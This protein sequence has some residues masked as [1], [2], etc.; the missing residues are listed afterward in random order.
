MNTDKDSLLNSLFDGKSDDEHYELN[1]ISELIIGCAFKVGNT[2]GC[3][4]LEKVYENAMVME[5]RKAGAFQATRLRPD[6]LATT[7][8]I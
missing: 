4:F 6:G 1:R 3:G 5:L 8:P 7:R 2:L